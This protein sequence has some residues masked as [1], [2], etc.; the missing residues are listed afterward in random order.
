MTIDWPRDR[1]YVD[2]PLTP[3]NQ[4]ELP[5]H[6]ARQVN[7]VL[8]LKAGDSIVLF[9]GDGTDRLATI[10]ESTRK[11]VRVDITE[12]AR[13]G[14]VLS[15]PEITLALALIKS[16]RFELAVQKATELGVSAIVPVETERCVVSLPA[17]RA[18][19]RV[20]RWQRIATEALEQ[21]ERADHVAIHMPVPFDD[22]I[23]QR[24]ESLDLIAAERTGQSGLAGH[25]LRRPDRVRI[26]IGPEGGFTPDEIDAAESKGWSRVTLGETILR[27]ETAAIASVAMIRALASQALSR[28]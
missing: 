3:G 18:Q 14:V 10:I 16:D 8:R 11:H 28:E 9:N 6:V 20:E 15:P 12:V 17:D 27:S 4:L 19:S 21:C 23:R 13:P 1:F 5:D 24:D 25:L 22:L 2:Q 26:L 7:R